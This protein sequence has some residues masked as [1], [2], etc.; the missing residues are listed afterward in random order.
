MNQKTA[1]SISNIQL[2]CA[3]QRQCSTGIIQARIVR[4]KTKQKW[5]MSILQIN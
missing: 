3:D 2:Y 5:W 1:N 4:R